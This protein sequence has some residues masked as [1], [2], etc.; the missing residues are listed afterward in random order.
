MPEELTSSSPG[1]SN[2]LRAIVRSD[3]SAVTKWPR[4]GII[5]HDIW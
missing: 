2:N 3:K 4:Q 1:S 5:I